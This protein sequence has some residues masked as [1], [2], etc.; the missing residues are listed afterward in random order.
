MNIYR[1]IWKSWSTQKIC[2]LRRL[3]YSARCTV[4]LAPTTSVPM[5]HWNKKKTFCDLSKHPFGSCTAH[6]PGTD[7]MFRLS[8]SCVL[9]SQCIEQKRLWN[10]SIEDSRKANSVFIIALLYIT[11]KYKL[12]AAGCLT[13][14]CLSS[15]S[16]STRRSWQ[17]SRRQ[18]RITSRTRMWEIYGVR[19]KM[20]VRMVNQRKVRTAGFREGRIWENLPPAAI[21]VR[22]YFCCFHHSSSSW[23]K[24]VM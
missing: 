17:S 21:P 20:N 2:S 7:L 24:W 8:L 4:C 6:R 10:P 16:W 11:L 19:W 9:T 5:N 22:Y 23:R 18:V 3:S 1:G 15:S 13:H 12:A 14:G